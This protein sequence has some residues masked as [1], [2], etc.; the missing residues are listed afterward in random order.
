MPPR[1]YKR[2]R[3]RQCPPHAAGSSPLPVYL[4]YGCADCA[5][6]VARDPSLAKLLRHHVPGHG[7]L[8]RSVAAW[9]M[10]SR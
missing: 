9:P 7:P 3:I 8:N 2:P 10:E 5:A 4:L 1:G 6:E